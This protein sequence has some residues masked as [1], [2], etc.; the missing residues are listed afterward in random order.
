MV[1][2]VVVTVVYSRRCSGS[3]V[4]VVVTVVVVVVVAVVVVVTVVRFC[5]L[6]RLYIALRLT[7]L[8]GGREGVPH[9]PSPLEPL[10]LIAAINI[11][12]K[13]L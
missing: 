3:I 9:P 12:I 10:P 2:V 4:V 11:I 5:T 7:Q 1:V 13:V 6:S 8:Q